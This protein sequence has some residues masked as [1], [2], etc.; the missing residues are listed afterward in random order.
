VRNRR[1]LQNTVLQRELALEL[2]ICPYC[3]SQS[4]EV[5]VEEEDSSSRRE[6][7]KKGMILYPQS[8]LT[9]RNTGPRNI[10]HYRDPEEEEVFLHNTVSHH[11]IVLMLVGDQMRCY[12]QY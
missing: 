8:I 3:M 9:G 10:C 6:L 5:V 2:S 11:Y 7:Q 4:N 1:S 12:S